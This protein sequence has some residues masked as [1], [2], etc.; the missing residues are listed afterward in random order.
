MKQIKYLNNIVE[1]NHRFIQKHIRSMLGL[2]SFRTATSTLTGVDAIHMIKKSRLI[3]GS[4]LFKKIHSAVI[5]NVFFLC[6]RSEKIE[7]RNKITFLVK[8]SY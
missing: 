5:W 4:S 7:F 1:Q 3:Y 2:K 6:T 8:Y